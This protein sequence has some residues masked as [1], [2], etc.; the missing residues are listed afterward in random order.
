MLKS[1]LI[2]QKNTIERDIIEYIDSLVVTNSQVKKA[3]KY[4]ITSGGKRLRPVL[5]TEF[6][7]AV[8][9]SYDQAK[10][11]AIAVE[12]IHTYSLIHDDLP[13]M[14]ND[15]FRR[16]REACHKKYGEAIALLAGDAMIGY[17]FGC[18]AESSVDNDCKLEAIRL[19]SREIG[20][21]GMI[22][23]QE[24]DISVIVPDTIE[25]IEEINYKKTAKLIILSCKLGL[26]ASGE[27]NL[28]PAEE[29]GKYIGLAFQ[30]IDDILDKKGDQELIGKPVGSDEKNNKFKITDL[31]GIEQSYVLAQRY[32]TKAKM[33]II[34]YK[35][36]ERLIEI[37]KKLLSRER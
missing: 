11:F 23:G 20:I 36:N 18:I 35:N 19:M 6:C 33:A 34:N 10:N 5:V 29:Y 32:T 13:C 1:E 7:K 17:A 21:D 30:I 37:T 9:G 16:G 8:G 31:L 12:L 28:Q 2:I 26:L 4:S 25:Q 15:D 14:D 27:K 3:I 24:K 22:G